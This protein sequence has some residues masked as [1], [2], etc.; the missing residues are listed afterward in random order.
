MENNKKIALNDEELEAVAGG[1]AFI[2]ANTSKIT[3][4]TH[5]TVY[6][7]KNCTFREI[8]D[9]CESYIDKYATEEEFDAACVAAL[10]EK[11]WI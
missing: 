10:K 5:P 7:Y 6:T 11:G 1:V 2:N 4:S 9:L 3:F 8:R